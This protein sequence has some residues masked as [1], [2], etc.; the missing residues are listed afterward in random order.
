MSGTPDERLSILEME[1]TVVNN[2]LGLLDQRVALLGARIEDIS[3]A[4][5]GVVTDVRRIDARTDS[6]ER[7]LREIIRH[8]GLDISG[9]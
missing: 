3:I 2:R 5:S 6:M 8:L 4:L 9:T 7:M 1:Y